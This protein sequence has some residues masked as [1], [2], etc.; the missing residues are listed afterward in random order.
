MPN[1]PF[2]HHDVRTA[3]FRQLVSRMANHAA[4]CTGVMMTLTEFAES[5]LCGLA[6]G[7]IVAF[8][9]NNWEFW[10]DAYFSFKW[11]NRP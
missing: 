6:G 3:D 11:S 7:A 9:I 10:F 2:Y 5:V 8:I 4:T 1:A